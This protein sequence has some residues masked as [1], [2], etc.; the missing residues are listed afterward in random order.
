ML[1]GLMDWHPFGVDVRILS[2]GAS[3]IRKDVVVKE[4][5]NWN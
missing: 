1:V 5:N 3:L 2:G 4:Q